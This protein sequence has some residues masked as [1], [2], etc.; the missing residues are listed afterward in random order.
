MN[1]TV[2][3][4]SKTTTSITLIWVPGFHGGA[5]QTFYIEYK[6]IST[7]WSKGPVI[8]CGKSS[9]LVNATVSDLLSG[10]EYIF[11]LYSKN[12]YGGKNVSI[13]TTGT[14][15]EGSTGIYIYIY[16][17]VVSTGFLLFTS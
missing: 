2:V 13:F 7:Q 6:T 4:S 9:D 14:T 15:S 5:N 12:I 17:K 3:H 1:F 10:T 11:Q 8:P 16:Q